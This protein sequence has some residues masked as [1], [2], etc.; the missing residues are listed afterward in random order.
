MNKTELITAVDQLRR[1]GVSNED[2]IITVLKGVKGVEVE[3]TGCGKM[4]IAPMLLD[5]LIAEME[6]PNE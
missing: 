6:K 2:I 4:T 3:V 5:A 1:Q